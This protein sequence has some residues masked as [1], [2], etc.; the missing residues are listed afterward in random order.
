MLPLEKPAELWLDFIGCYELM[1]ILRLCSNKRKIGIKIFH[2]LQGYYTTKYSTYS[3]DV[4]NSC[5]TD[6]NTYSICL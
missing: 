3:C 5:I 2:R 1:D 4:T 6:L